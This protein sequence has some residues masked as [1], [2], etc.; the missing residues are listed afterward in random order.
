VEH[1]ILRPNVVLKAQV[2]TLKE[3]VLCS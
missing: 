2:W 3:V 1:L